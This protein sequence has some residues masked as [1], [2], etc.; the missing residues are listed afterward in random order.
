MVVFIN[1]SLLYGTETPKIFMTYV[2]AQKLQVTSQ[3]F[4]FFNEVTLEPLIR[5]NPAGIC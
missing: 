4:F 5:Q 2:L 1:G 3:F